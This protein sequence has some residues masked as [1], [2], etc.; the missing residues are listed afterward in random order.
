MAAAQKNKQKILIRLQADGAY[1]NYDK[2]NNYCL[3][4]M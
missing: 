3:S 2:E 4:M 1:V